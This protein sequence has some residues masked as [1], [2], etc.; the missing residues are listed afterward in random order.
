VSLKKDKANPLEEM[1]PSVARLRCHAGT[2]PWVYPEMVPGLPSDV[3][4]HLRRSLRSEAF[5]AA[6]A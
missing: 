3:V 2:G 5:V 1:E 4:L 6:E